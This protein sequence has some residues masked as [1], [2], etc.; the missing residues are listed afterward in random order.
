MVEEFLGS[1]KPPSPASPADRPPPASRP[2]R[3]LEQPR[4]QCGDCW[5]GAGRGRLPGGCAATARG[6]PR[7]PLLLPAPCPW[8][9]TQGPSSAHVGPHSVLCFSPGRQLQLFQQQAWRKGAARTRDR[10]SMPAPWCH[11]EAGTKGAKM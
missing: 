10:H 7:P 2:G 8:V 3:R 11:P 4:R 1:T 9:P 5:R 6:S